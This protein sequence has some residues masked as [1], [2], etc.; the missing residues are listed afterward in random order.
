VEEHRRDQ[1]AEAVCAL[2]VTS[3]VRKSETDE[4][5]KIAIRLLEGDGHTVVDRIIVRNDSVQIKEA[6][7]G[8]LEDERIK[9]VV[10]SGGTGIGSKDMTVDTVSQLFD[11]RIEG[12]GELFRR[13]SFEEVGHSAILSRASAGVAAG[14][15]VFCLP[16]S[17][18]AVELAL[19][20]IIL[21]SLGHMIWEVE[22]GR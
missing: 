7:E 17:R 19:R 3:D 22:R 16:G 11:K 5:G 10:T 6:I 20:E 2:V 18:N 14:K 1:K 12:F 15:L 21:P 13:L 9:V 4:T 8:L